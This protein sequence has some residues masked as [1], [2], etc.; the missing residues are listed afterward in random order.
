MV[1]SRCRRVRSSRTSVLELEALEGR[2]LMA[3]Q[4]FESG[5]VLTILGDN[6]RNTVQV[7]DADGVF[8]E[9]GVS[10]IEVLADGRLYIVSSEIREI[11]V[12]LRGGNDSL[13]HDIG[14]SESIQTFIPDRVMSVAMGSGN[15]RVQTRVN[16]FQFEAAPELQALGPGSWVVHYDLGS[17]NDQAAVEMNAD[18]LG[19][20]R[21]TGVIDSIFSMGVMGGGG[22][23]TIEV[24]VMRALTSQLSQVEMIL[25]GGGG[26]DV[27]AV[28]ADDPWSVE[29]A[30]VIIERF[31]EAGNDRIFGLLAFEQAGES[32]VIQN[33]DTG[34]GNDTVTTKFWNRTR[35]RV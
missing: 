12:D 11:R 31:G 15:D 25:R 2:E 29:E 5:G 33:I 3:T 7:F 17:G 20:E 23:D 16:G 28:R 4:I 8:K 1:M 32:E 14:D 26:N 19:L 34:T 18:F 30:T 22:N 21:D 6:G 13:I 27:L 24:N 35:R 10:D 9:G